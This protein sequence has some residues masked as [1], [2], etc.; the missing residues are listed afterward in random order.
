MRKLIYS[1]LW[2]VCG[3]SAAGS[4]TACVPGNGVQRGKL[5]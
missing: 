2:A 4:G 1:L 3:M 5:V